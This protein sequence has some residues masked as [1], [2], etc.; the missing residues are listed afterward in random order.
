MCC[1]GTWT[2]QCTLAHWQSRQ[3]FAQAEKSVERPFQT[4]LEETRW[5]VEVFKYLSPKVSGY[6]RVECASGGVA[7]EDKVADLLR[8]DAQAWAGVESLYL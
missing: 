2:W 4:Y 8:D 7:D 3:A 5:R 1:C 6:Q